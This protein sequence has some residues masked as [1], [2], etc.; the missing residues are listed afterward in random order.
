LWGP[1]LMALPLLP[2]P[3]VP[4]DDIESPCFRI[5]SVHQKILPKMF[6]PD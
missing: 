2:L 1:P 5:S 4:L 6:M 3:F